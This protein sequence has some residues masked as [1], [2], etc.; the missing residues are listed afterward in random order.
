VTVNLLAVEAGAIG[1]LVGAE[2]LGMTVYDVQPG[3]GSSSYH[4]ELG[5]EEWL[6]VLAGRPTVRMPEGEVTL[7]PWDT[8]LFPE[9]E[10][11]AHQVVNRTQEPVR[12]AVWS[13]KQ[14]PHAVVYPED[15]RIALLPQGLLFRLSDALATWNG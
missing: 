6:I 13:T 5:R 10:A 9:G 14:E 12:V 3:D 15:D 8:L 1:A 11:G 2:L 4:Y 7:E